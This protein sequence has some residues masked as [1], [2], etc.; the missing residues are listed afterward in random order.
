MPS[1]EVSFISELSSYANFL[2]NAQLKGEE[3][4]ELAEKTMHLWKRAQHEADSSL[5]HAAQEVENVLKAPLS[6]LA[7]PEQISIIKA[8]QDYLDKSN[9]EELPLLIQELHQN[10]LAFKALCNELLLI[11]GVQ[12]EA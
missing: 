9:T 5:N 2:L 8:A 12:T 3:V 10:K 6:I 7:R 11:S 4:N 1:P